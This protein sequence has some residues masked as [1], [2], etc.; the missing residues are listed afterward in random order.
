MRSPGR[1]SPAAGPRCATA[2]TVPSCEAT[3]P[4]VPAY[5]DARSAVGI[6]MLAE[7]SA[8]RTHNSQR[9]LA[10]LRFPIEDALASRYSDD[11]E[12]AEEQQGR[13]GCQHDSGEDLQQRVRAQV[14]A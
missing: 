7:M 3:Y 5:P 13:G 11:V 9:I 2:V 10:L 6:A 8:S 14:D 4:S 12:D 1:S